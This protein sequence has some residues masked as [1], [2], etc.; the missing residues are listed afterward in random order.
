MLVDRKLTGLVDKG[1]VKVAQLLGID[2]AEAV[3]RT[4]SFFPLFSGWLYTND[5][6][7]LDW[8]RFQ[9]PPGRTNHERHC[10]RS[11]IPRGGHGSHGNTFGREEPSGRT[12]EEHRGIEA[13]ETVLD[14]SENQG[15]VGHLSGRG[16]GK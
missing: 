5:I 7:N 3:V 15:E 11:G 16:A 8:F 14:G 9:K 1:L 13:M 4:P 12:Q 2:Y 10:S 6:T